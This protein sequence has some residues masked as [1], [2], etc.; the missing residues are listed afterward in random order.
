MDAVTKRWEEKI[1]EIQSICQKMS[2]HLSEEECLDEQCQKWD[3]CKL[4]DLAHGLEGAGLAKDLR[5]K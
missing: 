1:V 5:G 3:P 4:N 2:E